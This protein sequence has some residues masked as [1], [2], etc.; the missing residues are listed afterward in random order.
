VRRVG[1]DDDEQVNLRRV[2]RLDWVPETNTYHLFYDRYDQPINDR[3]DR[4]KVFLRSPSLPLQL[5]VDAADGL[6]VSG[7][8]RVMLGD[9][10]DYVSPL[11]ASS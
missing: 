1:R 8:C 9:V 7:N 3:L 2:R 10:I 11:K 6:G 4:L 5:E